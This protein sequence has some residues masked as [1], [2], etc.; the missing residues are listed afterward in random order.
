METKDIVLRKAQ[1]DDWKSLY[2][3]VWSRPETAKY[4]IWKITVTEEDA[5]A[6]MERTIR[7]QETHD[8]Y[9]VYEKKSGEAIGFAGIERLSPHIFEE[10]G[11]A[12]GPEYVGRGYGKQVLTLLMEYAKALGGEQFVYS[13]RSG[14]IAS[15]A[16]ARSCGFRYQHCESKTD[17]RNGEPYELE[18]YEKE[19]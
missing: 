19:L 7:Y 15:K 5:R 10:T 16:L 4:M 13:T 17:P 3:N 11:I 6:R 9:M 2:R 14:N 12:L 8:T 18:V 1:F